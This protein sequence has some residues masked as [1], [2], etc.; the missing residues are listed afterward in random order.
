MPPLPKKKTSR[1]RQGTRRSHI[2]LAPVQTTTCSNCGSPRLAHTA[3]P[4]GGFY[5]GRQAVPVDEPRL[6]R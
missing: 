6:N 2:K 5:H 3:C 4:T 1:S